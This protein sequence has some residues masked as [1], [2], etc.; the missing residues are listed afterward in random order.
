MWVCP[1]ETCLFWTRAVELPTCPL[2]QTPLVARET[3]TVLSVSGWR[4]LSPWRAQGP[5]PTLTESFSTVELARCEWQG[6]P[7]WTPRY[8][9]WQQEMDRY[10]VEILECDQYR[11]RSFL[12]PGMTVL[13]VGAHVG[14]FSFLACSLGASVGALEPF[15]PN[16]LALRRN[17][18]THGLDMTIF[19]GAAFHR[20]T[21]AW[22]VPHPAS[23]SSGEVREEIAG[24]IPIATTRIDDLGLTALD[25]LKVDAEGSEEFVF[26]GAVKTLTRFRPTLAFSGYHFVHDG[27]R[28]VGLLRALVPAYRTARIQV[29]GLDWPE[30]VLWM[31]PER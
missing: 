15:P 1:H 21:T 11:A 17:L 3:H 26:A 2:C 16:L 22:L 25:F 18:K 27:A 28:L 13:D 9:K 10:F 5:D 30:R 12:Q 14:L 8:G 4:T 20:T 24:A 7:F 6:L 19:P 23:A 31:I 29:S